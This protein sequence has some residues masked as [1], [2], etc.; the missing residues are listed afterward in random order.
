MIEGGPWIAHFPN[1]GVVT[2]DSFVVLKQY[3]E[4]ED[5]PF[6]PVVL[7][8]SLYKRLSEQGHDMSGF[9]ENKPIPTGD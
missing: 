4:A 8:P 3:L 5:R 2:F 7:P 6:D 1:G 9:I